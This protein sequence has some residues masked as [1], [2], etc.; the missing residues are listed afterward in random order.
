MFLGKRALAVITLITLAL[1]MAACDRQVCYKDGNRE[2]KPPMPFAATST[3]FSPA[4][5]LIQRF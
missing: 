4:I 2:R 5:A 3:N 1:F